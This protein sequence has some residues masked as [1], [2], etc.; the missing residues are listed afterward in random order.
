[1]NRFRTLSLTS[2]VSLFLLGASLFSL[3]CG[4]DGSDEPTGPSE[5]PK[6]L[7]ALVLDLN[8]VKANPEQEKYEWFDFRPNV[9]KLILAGAA[10]TEHIAILWYT[11][12]DGEV[13]LH[14]HASTESV[15]VIE[16][17]QT[18]AKGDYPT[19]T[20]YFN[21]PGSGHA[22]ADS[23]GFFLLAYSSPP[24]FM[25]TDLIQEYT[26]VRIDTTADDLTTAY[27]FT[28]V[29]EG[30]STYPVPIDAEGGLT[31]ELLSI[32]SSE[33]YSFEGNYLLVL[34]GSCDVEEKTLGS[35]MLVVAK[36]LEPESYTV[37]ASK[38][39]ECLAM[40]L[41]F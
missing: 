28:E 11:V 4:D 15:Y 20:V 9:K 23:S 8:D 26:P 35:N 13:G 14:Y 29:K 36:T 10:E 21:P 39:S 3:G 19:G 38:D 24:D 7:D 16:G 6:E 2:S 18:D 30:V 27:E 32:T 41:S 37:T 1:M 22:I 12:E 40:G 33:T 31:A 34:R 5:E 25:S 17:T